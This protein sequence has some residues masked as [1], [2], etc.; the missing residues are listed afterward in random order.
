LGT[1]KIILAVSAIVAGISLTA[2]GFWST[3]AYAQSVVVNA[4]SLFAG[5]G[6]GIL[7]IETYLESSKQKELTRALLELL[8]P[9][10]YSA[11]RRNLDRVYGRFSIAQFD[12]I[13]TRFIQASGSIR[14]LE[15]SERQVVAAMLL[16]ENA[17]FRKDLSQLQRDMQ[18]LAA[19]G[20]AVID[21]TLLMEA[22]RCRAATERF[23]DIECPIN[24]QTDRDEL[25]TQFLNSTIRSFAVFS[26]M[27]E[28]SGRARASFTSRDLF[29]RLTPTRMPPAAG[30]ATRTLR[31]LRNGN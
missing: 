10:L 19:L 28:Q 18:T 4:G 12:A 1:T 8:E 26:F 31:K 11:Q 27:E 21:K 30:A 17:E 29:E 5:L 7:V 25:S 15:D 22:L 13:L 23:L 16:D 2:G 9:S 14:G 20:A 24:A 6:I 3:Q